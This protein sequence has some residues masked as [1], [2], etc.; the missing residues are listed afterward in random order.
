MAKIYAITRY[1]TIIGAVFRGWLEQVGCRRRKIPVE[2]NRCLRFNEMCSHIEHEQLYDRKKAAGL[3]VAPFIVTAFMGIFFMAPGA[4]MT[5]FVGDY[6]VFSLF[7]LWIG[8][9]LWTNMFPSMENAMYYSQLAE[10]SGKGK[11]LSKLM[12]SGAK[13]ES[14]GLTLVTSVL[15]AY[16]VASIFAMI[17]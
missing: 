12:L 10:E 1:L 17:L 15:A 2:D 16:L 5:I 9:S 8:I 11:I 3:C 4:L 6:S 7:F 14:T 13:L